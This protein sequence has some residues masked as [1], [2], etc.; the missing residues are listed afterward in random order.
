[1]RKLSLAAASPLASKMW[2]VHRYACPWLYTYDIFYITNIVSQT[3]HAVQHGDGGHRDARHTFVI[4]EGAR[5]CMLVHQ[6]AHPREMTYVSF[7][8]YITATSSSF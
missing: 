5:A 3:G 7:A 6:K 8:Q 4:G 2:V 1:M